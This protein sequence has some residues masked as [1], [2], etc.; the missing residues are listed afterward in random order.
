MGKI[1][2]PQDAGQR[3]RIRFLGA[4]MA[5]VCFATL[6]GRLYILQIRDHDFYAGRAEDQQL[7]DTVVPAPRGDIVDRNGVVLATS[8]TCWTIRAAPREMAEEDVEEA[9]RELARIL[10]L[11]E[12]DVLEKLSQRSSNDCLLRRQVE[13]EMADQV[14]QAV[15]EHGWQGIRILEDTKRVY[16]EGDFAGS[17]LGFV[18]VD[19]DGVAGLELEY[20]DLLKGQNGR[21][22]TAKNAWGYDLPESYS[23]LVQAQKGNTLQLT[24]DVNIQHYLENA[25]TFAAQQH[26]VSARAVGIVLDVKTGGVL[27]MATKPDYDPNQP[28]LIYDEEERARIDAIQDPEERSQALSLAQQ[29]QWRNKAVSDLYEPGSVFKLITA[30]AALDS[31]ACSL[32]DTFVCGASYSVAGVHFH[33]ANNKRH[34]VQNLALALQ[35][36]CNQS[37]IQIGARLGKD[38]FCQYF[39]ALGLCGATGIDLPAEPQKSEYYTADRMGPA[40]DFGEDPAL[41]GGMRRGKTAAH[42]LAGEL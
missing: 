2:G 29:A 10:E 35:N 15:L 23:T 42:H 27:A 22:M 32:T 28:R 25:L 12:G 38:A 4:A 13:K 34:G 31:G 36:S 21:V 18:N 41:K 19:G 5:L 26:H 11:E 39:E 40:G 9:A 24:L 14:Q 17:I 3:R 1:Q 7:R 16:P 33:C 30:S 8:V 37:F 20:N 6:V